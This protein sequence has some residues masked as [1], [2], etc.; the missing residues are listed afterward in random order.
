MDY[1]TK[2]KIEMLKHNVRQY[3]VARR[4]G[5]SESY[6]SRLLRNGLSEE[7]FDSIMAVIKE[8]E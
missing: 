3:E 2:A 4:L 5:F 7:R 8:D 1:S 6:L